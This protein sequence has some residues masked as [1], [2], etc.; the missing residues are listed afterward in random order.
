MF[1]EKSACT[2]TWAEEETCPSPVNT[3][4]HGRLQVAGSLLPEKN[5]ARFQ[6][7]QRYSNNG[8][9]RAK[10]S[11]KTFEPRLAIWHLCGVCAT[12]HASIPY[13][14]ISLISYV[15][16]LSQGG[17]RITVTHVVTVTGPGLSPQRGK[18][19]REIRI[20]VGRLSSM[21]KKIRLPQ[22]RSLVGRSSSKHC[23][24]LYNDKVRWCPPASVACELL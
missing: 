21:D 2:I 17:I 24:R 19:S 14:P 9:I 13:R 7:S 8:S 22:S 23:A 5:C 15:S 18:M 16:L 11:S 6:L 1:S 12:R 10:F 20:I 3:Q 4:C